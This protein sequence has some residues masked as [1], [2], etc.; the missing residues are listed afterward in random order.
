MMF[1]NM[2]SR[3]TSAGTPSSHRMTGIS[4]SFDWNLPAG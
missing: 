3:T 4:I 1:R 2:S